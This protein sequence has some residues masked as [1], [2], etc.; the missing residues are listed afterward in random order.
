MSIGKLKS[1]QK[2]TLNWDEAITDAKTLLAEAQDRDEQ[3]RL[4]AVIEFFE[5]RKR[6]GVKWGG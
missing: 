6:S 5:E 4:N 2:N 3:R 1:E